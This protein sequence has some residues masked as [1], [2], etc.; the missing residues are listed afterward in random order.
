MDRN[1]DDEAGLMFKTLL[2][3]SDLPAIEQRCIE[4]S[5]RSISYTLKRSSKRRSIGL[6]IDEAGLAV[7]MPLRASEK[8]LQEVLREKAHWII[9]KL[10]GWQANKPVDVHWTDGQQIHFMGEQLTLRVVDSLFDAPPLLRGRQLFVHVADSRN[11]SVVE[12]AV[13]HWYRRE[14]EVLLRE[15]VEHFAPLLNVS[16]VQVKLSSARTQWGSCTAR[17][18]I[19][20]NW[21]LVKMPLRLAD[22]VVVHE[23]AH[24]VELNHS[25]AFWQV[26]KS[27]CPGYVKLRKDLRRWSPVAG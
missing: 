22:Y 8:W 27:V 14:A 1:R 11:Q 6:N 26:V 23:L 18:A 20:L 19:S 16:P 25:A 24:L 9:E 12:Q 17:G 10:D 13:T 7:S 21:Q 5:G 15:R 3:P 2:R 4:L